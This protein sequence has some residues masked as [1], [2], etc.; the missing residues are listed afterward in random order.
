MRQQQAAWNG[1]GNGYGTGERD[2][3]EELLQLQR[4]FNLF[5]CVHGQN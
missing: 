4:G 3:D 1:N 5:L 2:D